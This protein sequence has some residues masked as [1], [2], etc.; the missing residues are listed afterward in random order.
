MGPELFNADGKSFSFFPEQ[1]S[2]FATQVDYLTLFA[3]LI[4]VVF[5]GLVLGLIVLFCIKFGYRED[6]K[7]A[8]DVPENIWFEGSLTIVPFVVVMVLF[9]W[10]AKLYL[11]VYTPPKGAT[12]LFVTGKQWMWRVQHPDGKREIN[13]LTVPKGVPIQLTMTSEDVIHAFFVPAFR[14]KRDVVPGRYT[15]VW[16]EAT[17]TGTFHLF[18]A[19]Y[20]G[21]EH[22]YMT[23]KVHVLEPDAYERWLA[24]EKAGETLVQAGAKLFQKVGCVQCHGG[25]ATDRG[26]PLAGVF[27]RKRLLVDGREV[28]ADEDYLRRSM[29]HPQKDIVK[30]FAPVMPSF[31]GRLQADQ[32]TKIVAYIKSL[33]GGKKEVAQR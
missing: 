29:T 21:T 12:E 17:K 20:C 31:S 10:G 19:E 7:K 27:G 23:G 33:E 25:L 28:Q 22:A 14:I 26:P 5:L 18:C 16:F 6:H 15:T 13:T 32:I 1:A 30:G 11:D 24:N 8:W 4:L 3:V 2:T 9:V